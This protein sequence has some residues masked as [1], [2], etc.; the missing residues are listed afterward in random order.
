MDSSFLA[1]A[2]DLDKLLDEFEKNEG[3][4]WGIIRA[5]FFLKQIDLL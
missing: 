2:D 3:E 5:R 1:A 4:M